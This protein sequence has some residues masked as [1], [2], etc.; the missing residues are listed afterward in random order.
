MPRLTK[1]VRQQLLDQNGGFERRTYYDSRNSEEERIYRIEDG[2]L[3]IRAIGKTSWADSRYD[4]TW[5]A[6]D[7][8]E[9]RFLYKYLD[10][11]DYDEEQE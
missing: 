2:H 11:L 4:R 1:H 10:D 7:E 8:E 6:D 9:H 5:I 3:R